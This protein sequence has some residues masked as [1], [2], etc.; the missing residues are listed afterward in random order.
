MSDDTRYRELIPVIAQEDVQR[1]LQKDREYGASWKRRGGVGA[2][3]T[4]VRKIDRLETMVAKYGWN[5]FEA[6]KSSDTSESLMDTIADL[7]CYLDL[8]EAEI[9]IQQRLLPR[10]Q[11]LDGDL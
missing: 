4:M 11:P 3:M 10:P 2:Y 1:V 6:A 5:V 7:R 8:I 9:R